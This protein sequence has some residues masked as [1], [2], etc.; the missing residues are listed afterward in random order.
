MAGGGDSVQVA[1]HDL[2]IIVGAIGLV[3]AIAIS[4]F[5]QPLTMDFGE[6]PSTQE[7]RTL[8][9]G[10][11]GSNDD[12]VIDATP[13]CEGN[14]TCEITFIRILD[15]DGSELTSVTTIEAAE[16]GSFSTSIPVSSGGKVTLEMSGQGIWELEITAQRQIP[17]QF[18]PPL[19]ALL[20]LVWGVWR[21]LQESPED[22]DIE[23]IAESA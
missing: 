5:A 20:L 7:V 18:L 1:P 11:L 13:I 19:I 16:D 10:I 15:L 22:A 14:D 4:L 8:S 9:L 2:S 6:S 17:I 12:I 21:K 23:E 3:G